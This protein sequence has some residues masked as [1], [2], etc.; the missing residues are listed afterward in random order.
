MY[1]ISTT[2]ATISLSSYTDALVHENITARYNSMFK[3]HTSLKTAFSICSAKPATRSNMANSASVSIMNRVSMQ[4]LLVNGSKSSHDKC[5]TQI[6]RFSSHAL[7]TDS[8][9]GPTRTPGSILNTC[10]SLSS[11]GESFAKDY[12]DIECVDSGYY[13]SLCWI[14]ENDPTALDLTLQCGS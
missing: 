3:G 4:V 10:H 1:W 7:Q 14:L 6:M 2:S 12:K 8:P 5:S 13:N 11:L 9:I